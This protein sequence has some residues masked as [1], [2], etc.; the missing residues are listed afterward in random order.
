MN[1]NHGIKINRIYNN[2]LRQI[3]IKLKAL[4]YYIVLYHGLCSWQTFFM[5]RVKKLTIISKLPLSEP[6]ARLKF[7]MKTKKKSFTSNPS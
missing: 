5:E 7:K 4:K 2:V 6:L 3:I 1:T